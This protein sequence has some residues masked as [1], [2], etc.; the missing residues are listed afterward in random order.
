MKCTYVGALPQPT[1]C[2]TYVSF[3]VTTSPP[4]TGIAKDLPPLPAGHRASWTLY[5]TNRAKGS[6]TLVR[7]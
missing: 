4:Q 3:A 7:N 5:V 2:G 6:F 1:L